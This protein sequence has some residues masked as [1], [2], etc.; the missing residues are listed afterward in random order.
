MEEDF[1][2][3]IIEALDLKWKIYKINNFYAENKH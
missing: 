2:R 3:G 1:K